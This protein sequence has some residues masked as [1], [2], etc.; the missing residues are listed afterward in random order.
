MLP[1]DIHKALHTLGLD[2]LCIADVLLDHM[3]KDEK[4]TDEDLL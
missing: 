3:S 4:N 1:K 2:V